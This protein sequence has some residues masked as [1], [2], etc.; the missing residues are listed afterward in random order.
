M[1]NIE[2]N[3]TKSQEPCQRRWPVLGWW[4]G[5]EGKWTDG[6]D[7]WAE[8]WTGLSEGLSVRV[9]EVPRWSVQGW[10]RIRKAIRIFLHYRPSLG[11]GAA[12]Y[13]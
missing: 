10:T 1:Q 4:H 12:S 7:I 3:E 9:R 2:R 11:G 6:E 8:E 13:M 5:K